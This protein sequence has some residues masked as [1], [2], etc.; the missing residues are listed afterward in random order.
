MNALV[1]GASGFI[2]KYLCKALAEKGHIVSGLDVFDEKPMW[3][4]KYFKADITIL[5]DNLVSACE[6]IDVIFHLAGKVH[7]LAEIKADIE[8]YNLV[9][10]VGTENLLKAAA[11]NSVG[12]FVFFSTIKV[13]GEKIPDLDNKKTPVDEQME[14]IP[15]TPY[16]QSKLDAEKLV[17]S[18]NYIDDVTILRPCM[19]YGPEAKGNIIKLIKAI[20]MGIPFLLPEFNNKRSMV[21]V[22]DI[23]RAVILITEKNEAKNQTYIVSDGK[24]YSTKQVAVAITQALRKKQSSLCI[25]AFFFTILGKMGDWVGKIV[26]RR[27]FFDSDVLNKISGSAWFSSKKIERELG[28]KPDYDLEKALPEMLKQ[29]EN[30]EC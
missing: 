15:D 12:K 4:D 17:L 25:P 29:E 3:C 26:G 14:T 10:T 21:D 30:K 6:N 1:T 16:G 19:V 24:A 11:E 23:V 5:D 20:K 28:F 27:F 18:G 13:Y 2:G 22:R 8:Q 7:A 9:N